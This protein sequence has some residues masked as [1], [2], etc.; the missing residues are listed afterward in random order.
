MTDA[1]RPKIVDVRT[2]TTYLEK[3]CEARNAIKAA[4]KVFNF[5]IGDF[6]VRTISGGM[7]II[8][9]HADI[10][11]CLD[12]FS[13][14]RHSADIY[15]AV[16]ITIAE[17]GGLIPNLPKNEQHHGSIHINPNPFPK[18]TCN[19]PGNEENDGPKFLKTALEGARGPVRGM[20]VDEAKNILINIENSTDGPATLDISEVEEAHEAIKHTFTTSDIPRVG[21]D[22][23]NR[24]LAEL[25]GQNKKQI[26]PTG[27]AAEF[28]RYD[29]NK[30]GNKT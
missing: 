5:D 27:K 4:F 20:D 9:T 23:L 6:E 28:L 18:S 3:S 1:S 12:L 17:A 21:R 15:A 16:V 13:A 8:F 24:R 2:A 10:E 19:E 14:G 11:R 22:E 7:R 30:D 26:G 29:P 25:S